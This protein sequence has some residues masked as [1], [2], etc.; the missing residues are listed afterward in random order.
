MRDLEA[1]RYAADRAFRQ[2]DAADPLNRLVTGELETRWNKALARVTEVEGKITA[3]DG[4]MPS[5]EVA[6]ISPATLAGDLKS[7]WSAPTTGAR[8]KKRIVRTVIREVV[9]DIDAEAA[10]I[11]LVIH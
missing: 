4:A 2:Y 1:A 6:P 8:L 5:R 11:I 3:H 10:E 7:V 9:A